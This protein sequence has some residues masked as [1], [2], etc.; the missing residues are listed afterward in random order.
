MEVMEELLGTIVYKCKDK[1]HKNFGEYLKQK[2]YIRDSFTMFSS[3]IKV[4]RGQVCYF[5]TL[6]IHDND[7]VR[8]IKVRNLLVQ[9]GYLKKEDCTIDVS[10]I[11]DILHQLKECQTIK[12][13]RNTL[14]H[15]VV[16]NSRRI[17]DGVWDIEDIEFIQVIQRV[18]NTEVIKE[19]IVKYPT[20]HVGNAYETG[21]YFLLS[22]RPSDLVTTIGGGFNYGSTNVIENCPKRILVLAEND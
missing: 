3:E 17:P 4:N 7:Y 21:E 8:S 9:H 1:F 22:D 12:E 11:A 10:T 14:G 16:R 2:V 19:F 13:I 20:F 18:E 5:K 6:S 15:Q